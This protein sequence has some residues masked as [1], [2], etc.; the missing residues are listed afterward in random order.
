[1]LAIIG[2]VIVF[3]AV[4][5]GYLMEHG[6][7]KVLVQ[8]AE[9]IIIA[10]A[11][12]GTVLIANPLHVLKQIVGGMISVFKGSPFTGARYLASLKL[13]YQLLNKARRQGL[14]S[15]ETDIE[16]PANSAIFQQDA[17]FLASSHVKDFFCDSM[18]MAISGVDA[19][20]L[21]QLIELDLEV[22]HHDATMPIASLNTVADSLPGLGIVAAVLGVVITMGALGGPPEEI[23]HN[24]AAALVGT[25]LG[26]LLCYGLIGPLASNMA[27]IADDEKAYM[28][29]LRVLIIS[30]LKGTAPILAVEAARRA[31][32]G[33]VRPTFKEL[34]EGCRGQAAAG[35]GKAEA[36]AEQAQAAGG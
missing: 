2:I 6:N 9:L 14:M 13:A 8:P 30:F 11:A 31:V 24:V 15:L 26:I 5:G 25:F 32:P 35:A 10:G 17:A 29:V 22:L 1:M 33:H 23:G 19:F 18:R 28:N 27:K 36:P 7:V 16:D 3:G 12:G 4:L 34:E 21:D 20:E